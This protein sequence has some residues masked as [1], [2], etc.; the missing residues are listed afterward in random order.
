MYSEVRVHVKTL[1]KSKV[2]TGIEIIYKFLYCINPM[3]NH[4]ILVVMKLIY[5]V[6]MIYN[7]II[8]L[9]LDILIYL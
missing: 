3:I 9:K 5:K 8:M 4:I 1:N 2:H 7:I 6:S